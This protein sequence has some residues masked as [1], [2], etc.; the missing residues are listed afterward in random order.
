MREA[1]PQSLMKPL[2]PGEAVPDFSFLDQ[3]K[4]VIRLSQYR[5]KVVVLTFI[6]THCPL[7]E[8]CPRMS[9]NFAEVDK[10]LAAS[11]PLY[12]RTHL[13]SISFDPERD[14]PA[15]LRSYGGANTGQYTNEPFAP[16]WFA[17][18]RRAELAPLLEFFDVSAV[19]APGATLTHSLSTVVIGPDGRVAKWY[20]GNGWTP[21]QVVADVEHA[22]T[23]PAGGKGA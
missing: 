5:G 21:A 2:V 10:A 19:P 23:V 6:Y 13:L 15:V 12:D 8:Y 20:G 17:P 16:W 7:S 1:V 22:V 11:P 14:T 9:R 4:Q 3:S 18:P